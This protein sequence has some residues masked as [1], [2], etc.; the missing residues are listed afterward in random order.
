MSS[1]LLLRE[2]FFACLAV[3]YYLFTKKTSLAPGASVNVIV[4]AGSGRNMKKCRDA[5]VEAGIFAVRSVALTTILTST[6]M[7]RNSVDGG[8]QLG[9]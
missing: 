2:A 1:I 9:V 3:A 6:S 8:G 7:M 4:E 5:R